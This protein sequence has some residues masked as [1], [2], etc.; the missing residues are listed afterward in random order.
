MTPCAQ[1]LDRRRPALVLRKLLEHP[2]VDFRLREGPPVAI[3]LALAALHVIEFQILCPA[4]PRTPAPQTLQ[5]P[6]ARQNRC[7][8]I[9]IPPYAV[10]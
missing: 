3:A 6:F 9:A 5:R 2:G 1:E 7:G 10:V 8:I 4:A